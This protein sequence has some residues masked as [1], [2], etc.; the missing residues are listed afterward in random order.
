MKIKGDIK[1]LGTWIT[2]TIYKNSVYAN[3]D[4]IF[5]DFEYLTLK[6]KFSRWFEKHPKFNRQ[7]IYFN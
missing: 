3:T 2:F 4:K 7:I 5:S 6:E 1:L